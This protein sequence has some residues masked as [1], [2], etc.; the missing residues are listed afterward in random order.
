MPDL[1]PQSPLMQP[2][3]YNNQEYFTSQYFHAQYLANSPHGGKY[4]R[5]PNF[6]RALRTID[7]Y[8]HYI[9]HADIVELSWQQGGFAESILDSVFLSTGYKPLTLLNATAQLALSH[10]LDDLVSQALSVA[11]NRQAASRVRQAAGLLPHEQAERELA[12]NL[13]V[14]ELLGVPAHIGQQEAVKMVKESTGI[15]YQRLLSGAPAQDHIPGE[16]AM[17]EPED[18]AA[19]F[20]FGARKGARLNKMLEA[21]GWQIPRVGGGWEATPQ[22]EGLWAPHAWHRDSKSGY[23]L[24]WKTLAVRA[25]LDRRGW[26]P[27]PEQ[28]QP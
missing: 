8:Q 22:A 3:H 17:L 6:L 7:T 28:A 4:R 11:V 20:G 26:L 19:A 1:I 18:L 25:E 10:H 5:H 2:V 14:A 24:K 16:A 9:E 21:C 27:A 15:D 13:R 23:N 12:S